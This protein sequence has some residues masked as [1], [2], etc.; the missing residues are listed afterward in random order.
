MPHTYHYINGQR[1]CM[2]RYYAV[3]E[4]NAYKQAVFKKAKKYLGFTGI[5]PDS[6][7]CINKVFFIL[8]VFLIGYGVGCSANP[9]YWKRE[10]EKY[11]QA[12]KEAIQEGKTFDPNEYERER[13]QRIEENAMSPI[14]IILI[15][16]GIVLVLGGIVS[17]VSN[18]S[19]KLKTPEGKYWMVIL[20]VIVVV[21]LVVFI[22][23][24]SK[25]PSGSNYDSDK[26]YWENS[27][28][29]TD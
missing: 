8:L 24:L 27:R 5:L 17:V 26:E 14:T 20:G 15:L 25:G 6:L 9:N 13:R 12:K 4:N 23:V 18:I 21:L 1:V 28:M 11:E 7:K 16:G 3:A 22:S 19:D 2:E 10:R 29:H